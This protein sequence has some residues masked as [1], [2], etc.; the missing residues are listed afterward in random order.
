MVKYSQLTA[1]IYKPKEIASMIGVITKTL[2]DWDDKAHFFDRTPDTDRCYMTKETL[3]PFL[4]KKGV[5]VDDSQDNK[6]DVI[7]ARVSSRDQKQNGD[8]DRQVLHLV[9][10]YSDLKNV[11]FYLK[12]AVA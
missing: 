4:N 5:L 1:E 9:N 3:I 6:R 7:F 8:L 10:S 2:R 11:L 12:L